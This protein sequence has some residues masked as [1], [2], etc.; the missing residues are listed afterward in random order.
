MKLS[1]Y[2]RKSATPIAER[3]TSTIVGLFRRRWHTRDGCRRQPKRWLPASL[4]LVA[5]PSSR[6]NFAIVVCR[7]RFCRVRSDEG[8]SY[9]NSETCRGLVVTLDQVRY[10]VP[11]A[12][13]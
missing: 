6:R 1:I 5:L 2:I 10:P 12:T 7:G 4:E 3:A 11:E 8:I 13:L 9:I